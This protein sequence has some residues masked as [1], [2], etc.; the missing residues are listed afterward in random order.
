MTAMA[1]M[2]SAIAKASRNN[3]APLGTLDPRRATMPTANAM[4]VAIGIPHPRRASPPS[5]DVKRTYIA[6]GITI[7]PRGRHHRKGGCFG[8]AQFADD[9]FSLYLQANHKE[10]DRH[11]AVVDDLVDGLVEVDAECL[12]REVGV[13]DVEIGVGK[14]RVRPDDGADCCGEEDDPG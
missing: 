1:P 3:F 8:I 9:E 5:P 14:R 4:S 7:P 12:D 2:S 11:Q 13:E 6:A 10:E